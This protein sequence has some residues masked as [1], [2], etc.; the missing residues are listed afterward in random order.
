M[1]ISS[2]KKVISDKPT[3]YTEN[4]NETYID[5]FLV[6]YPQSWESTSGK[7]LTRP[8]RSLPAAGPLKSS[9]MC[10][11]GLASEKADVHCWVTMKIFLFFLQDS[12]IKERKKDSKDINIPELAKISSKAKLGLWVLSGRWVAHGRNSPPKESKTL[13]MDPV[14]PLFKG[15]VT[16]GKLFL[17]L[18]LSFITCE[19]FSKVPFSTVRPFLLP[20]VGINLNV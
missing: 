7:R 10:A 20:Y 17:S 9:K 12:F 6:D 1:A 11:E 4:K 19:V 16:L 2:W 3:I 13:R 14:A 8:P 18:H 15:W 5:W